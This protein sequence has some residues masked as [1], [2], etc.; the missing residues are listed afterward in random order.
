MR[1]LYVFAHCHPDIAIR[2]AAELGIRC[3]EHASFISQ[4]TAAFLAQ[5][6]TYVV[7]TLAVVKALNDDGAKL[8][9]PEVSIR[10]LAGMYDAML[11]GIG[12]MKKAGVKMGFGTDLLAQ[13]QDRQS[14]EFSL[15]AEVLPAYDIL[16]SATS[17]AAEILMED[18][19]LGVVAPG[20]HADVLVVDGDPL[21]DIN[22]VA[23]DGKKLSLIMRDGELVKN[24][25]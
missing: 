13:H 24:R 17:V 10:K 11:D 14:M 16:T 1:G 19:R 2:R 8:G 6:K 21:K 20:A 18:G 15:R 25:L 23:A 5:K 12:Y 22:L 4:E 9:F 7:P 3:I